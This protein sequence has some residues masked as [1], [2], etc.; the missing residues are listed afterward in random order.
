MDDDKDAFASGWAKVAM[1][2]I[3]GC[4]T[5]LVGIGGWTLNKVT[6]IGEE[7]ASLRG[8]F[9]TLTSAIAGFQAQVAAMGT[10]NAAQDA[11]I[12]SLRTDFTRLEQIIIDRYRDGDL[13][14]HPNKASD[15]PR[16]QGQQ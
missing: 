3:G 16:A 1:A 12:S 13:L 5:V 10:I 11:S 15:R 8:D 14:P 6:Q 7:E 4:L 9:H 2:L